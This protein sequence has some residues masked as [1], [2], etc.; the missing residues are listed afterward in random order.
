MKDYFV[1]LNKPI[2]IFVYFKWFKEI[3]PMKKLIYI[4]DS[5]K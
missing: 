3:E 1:N 4:V 5:N 2:I